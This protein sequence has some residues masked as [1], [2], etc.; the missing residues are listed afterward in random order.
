MEFYD[1]TGNQGQELT[2]N[3]QSDQT[4]VPTFIIPTVYDQETGERK[5]SLTIRPDTTNALYTGTLGA[6]R[7]RPLTYRNVLETGSYQGLTGGSAEK[8]RQMASGRVSGGPYG[9]GDPPLKDEQHARSRDDGTERPIITEGQLDSK[10]NEASYRDSQFR[11]EALKHPA[12]WG[13][14]TEDFSHSQN[15]AELRGNGKESK[16]EGHAVMEDES[17]IRSSAGPPKV[18]PQASSYKNATSSFIDL[19]VHVSSAVI[20]PSRDTVGSSD[21]VDIRSQ[22]LTAKH[23]CIVNYL[24]T[25]ELTQVISGLESHGVDHKKIIQAYLNS[26]VLGMD[27]KWSVQLQ[28][29]TSDLMSTRAKSEVNRHERDMTCKLIRSVV[30]E[31]RAVSRVVMVMNCIKQFTLQS[32]SIFIKQLRNKSNQALL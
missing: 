4:L 24:S 14:S 25:V 7:G 29:L 19:E 21:C 20:S 10:P 15:K 27:S 30:A 2:D 5:G 12:E 31:S 23:D 9:M 6:S 22:R 18:V 28:V 13:Q 8:G 26:S 3:K 16:M 32:C 17:Y 11:L 1:L